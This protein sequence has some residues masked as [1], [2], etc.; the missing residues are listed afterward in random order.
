MREQYVSPAWT[1]H[2]YCAMLRHMTPRPN[3]MAA[4]MMDDMLMKML[5]RTFDVHRRMMT[6][7]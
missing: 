3:T 6:F 4:M 7:I 1:E 2:T 5:V